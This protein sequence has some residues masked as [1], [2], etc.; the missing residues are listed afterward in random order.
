MMENVAYTGHAHIFAGLQN[1]QH[2][3]KTQKRTGF[4]KTQQKNNCYWVAIL[5]LTANCVHG[6]KMQ[7]INIVTR[8]CKTC[9]DFT[10]QEAQFTERV[11]EYYCLTCCEYELI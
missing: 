11:V 6:N 10:K 2:L 8:K 9:G 5:R 3:I 1:V 7:Q 4:G